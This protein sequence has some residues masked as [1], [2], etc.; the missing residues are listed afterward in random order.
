[1]YSRKVLNIVRRSQMKK[2]VLLLF[3]FMIPFFVSGSL[4]GDVNGNG[5]VEV[6]DYLLIRKHLLKSPELTG[7]NKNRADVNGDGNVTASDYI[8]IRRIIMGIISPTPIPNPTITSAP[9]KTN[10]I[11]VT[12]SQSWTTTYST[13]A[14][15]INFTGATKAIGK[16]T[17][18]IRSQKDSSGTVVNYFSIPTS[19]TASLRLVAKASSGTYTV[20]IRA[21]AAGNSS[22]NS[23]Y[24]DIKMKVTINKVPVSSYV[25]TA[26]SKY[27]K[28]DNICS[29]SSNTLKYRVIKSGRQNIV[30]V[31]VKD[32]VA[33]LNSAIA[34][35]KGDKAQNADTLLANEISKYGYEDKCM[36][37]VNA[38]F[39]NTSTG[40]IDRSVIINK[41]KIVRD[42]GGAGGIIGVNKKGIL[43][44]YNSSHTANSLINEG[45]RNTFGIS[46]PTHIDKSKDDTN[47]TQI[48]QI[49]ENNFAILSGSGRVYNAG[50]ELKNLTGC[51]TAYNLDGGGSRKLYYKNQTTSKMTRN[52]GGGRKVPDMLYFVEQ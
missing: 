36:V 1:M 21:K 22:Y 19:T 6:K 5:K 27:S 41:G 25:I 48:C 7:D 43:T 49:D 9:K 44:Q 20:V 45:V 42:N 33:Q 16:V 13:S 18:S 46:S 4:V 2:I 30:L 52:F 12:A 37:A 23:G 40:S 10:P 24:K 34:S 35:S 14:R 29:C 51:K 11:T 3:L 15:T 39:F 32:P 47:R 50:E 38:S 17:Y 28:Y 8:M 31:W 26:D